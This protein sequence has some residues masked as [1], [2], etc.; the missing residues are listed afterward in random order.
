M[1]KAEIHLAT[2]ILRVCQRKQRTHFTSDSWF[3]YS[4]ISLEEVQED[5]GGVVGCGG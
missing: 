3:H 2:T 4:S 5:G 1:H